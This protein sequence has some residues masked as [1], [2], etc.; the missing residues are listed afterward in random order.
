MALTIQPITKYLFNLGA[1][2]RIMTLF[3]VGVCCLFG[4][5]SFSVLVPI[6]YAIVIELDVLIR[7]NCIHEHCSQPYAFKCT[8]TSCTLISAVTGCSWDYSPFCSSHLLHCFFHHVFHCLLL[9]HLYCLFILH[10]YCLFLLHLYC[11]FLF[12]LYCLFL[13]HLY[14]LFPF[15][16]LLL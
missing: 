3:V 13:L 12:H 14:C 7:K 11:L 1:K 6:I 8:L 4:L 5:L 2:E 16:H 15:H 10:L 9:F